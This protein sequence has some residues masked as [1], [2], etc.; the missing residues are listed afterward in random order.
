ML[1]TILIGFCTLVIIF[2]GYIL[3]GYDNEDEDYDTLALMVGAI[4]LCCLVA[5]A[6]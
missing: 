1:E 5:V 4:A 3:T 6:K 2:C